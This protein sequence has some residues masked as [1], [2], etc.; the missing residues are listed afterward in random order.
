MKRYLKINSRATGA[1][2]F[3]EASREELRALIAIM[4]HGGKALSDSELASIASIS[5]PRA[6]AAVAFWQGAGIVE[7][8][9]TCDGN[10]VEEFERRSLDGD[11]SDISGVEAAREIRDRDL[12]DMIEACAHLLGKPTLHTED[13]KKLVALS[14]EYDLDAEYVVTLAAFVTSKSKSPTVSS[15]VRRAVILY[16]KGIN[17]VEKLEAYIK[18]NDEQIEC[19]MELR[20]LLGI[21]RPLTKSQRELASVWLDEYG[22]GMDVIGEAYDITVN[23]TDKVSFAYMNKILTAWHEAGCT[24][25]ADCRKKAEA[26]RAEKR[27]GS[28]QKKPSAKPQRPEK[29]RYGNFDTEDFLKRALERSY[30][31][32]ED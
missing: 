19:E 18:Q 32:Q 5:E 14:T 11:L 25:V 24:T 28:A 31:S 7:Q 2:A 8:V 12:A 22:F 23:N 3:T 26:D 20:R 9:Q 13:T 27:L 21:Y 6:R 10:I 15:I 16:D 29:P 30:G 4:E 1:E 17:T